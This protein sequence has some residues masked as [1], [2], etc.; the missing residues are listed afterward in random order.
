M[1][2]PFTSSSPSTLH[3]PPYPYSLPCAKRQNSLHN[4]QQ[5]TAMTDGPFAGQ[6]PGPC[7]KKVQGSPS[8]VALHGGGTADH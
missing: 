1:R 4:H 3:P 6:R 7:V 8:R 2:H 5:G